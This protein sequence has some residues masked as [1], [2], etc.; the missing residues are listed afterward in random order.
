VEKRALLLL[1]QVNE[2]SDTLQEKQDNKILTIM[3]EWNRDVNTGLDEMEKQLK[4]VLAEKQR[5][6]SQISDEKYWATQYLSNEVFYT[7]LKKL[8]QQGLESPNIKKIVLEIIDQNDWKYIDEEILPQIKSTSNWLYEIYEHFDMKSITDLDMFNLFLLKT[9]KHERLLKNPKSGKDL[10]RYISEGIYYLR[11]EYKQK[12]EDALILI[13]T[14]PFAK[15]NAT[16]DVVSLKPGP[17]GLHIAS[18][19]ICMLKYQ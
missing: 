6:Q 19:S 7:F 1:L 13:L 5:I 18:C 12:Y 4:Y 9:L 16:N 14:H 17:A 2:S 11:H 15:D 10:A 8:T 3:S